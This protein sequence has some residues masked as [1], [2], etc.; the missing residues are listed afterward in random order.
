MAK[1]RIGAPLFVLLLAMPIGS[2]EAA[3]PDDLGWMAGAWCGSDESQQI[4]ETWYA[5]AG[6]E[7]IGMS[8]TVEGGRLLSFEFMRIINVEGV[9]SYV[10]QPNGNPPTSFKR[11]D[12]GAGWIRFENKEHDFPQRIEYR[13]DGDGLIAE[14]AGPGAEGKEEA[15]SY[16]YTRCAK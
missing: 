5:P 15:I 4:E 12:G 7:T 1:L 3:P 13:R 6:G 11:R 14:I 2:V 16:R 9:V 10:A 8:R